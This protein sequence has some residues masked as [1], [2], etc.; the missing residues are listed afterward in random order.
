ML[1]ISIAI[2]TVRRMARN[3]APWLA[4][5]LVLLPLVAAIEAADPQQTVAMRF[6][7]RNASTC[8]E[9]MVASTTPGR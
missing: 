4:V 2:L 7:C 9:V 3:H 1:Q 6:P 8:V 5:V